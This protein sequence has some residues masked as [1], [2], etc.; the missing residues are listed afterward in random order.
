MSSPQYR[1]QTSYIVPDSS[2][3]S[4][5]ASHTAIMLTSGRNWTYEKFLELALER[6]ILSP[7]ANKYD[8]RIFMG[9]NSNT[10]GYINDRQL[11][12][13]EYDIR[14]IA[15]VEVW[16]KPLSTTVRERAYMS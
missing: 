4:G 5:N 8:V 2:A 9:K 3:P 16:L 14:Q 10:A 7:N 6:G 11:R 12:R 1:V 15:Y 13:G